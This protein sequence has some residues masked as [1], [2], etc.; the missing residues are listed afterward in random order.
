MADFFEKLKNAGDFDSIYELGLKELD[1]IAGGRSIRNS[2]A[3]DHGRV[4]Q[5]LNEKIYNAGSEFEE[6]QI[7]NKYWIALE[8]W[9]NAVKNAPEDGP[10][11]YL[12][13]FIDL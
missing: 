13:D 12:S 1:S 5:K 6:D 10:D 3:K 4:L 11:I 2:E 9:R 8:K 7:E